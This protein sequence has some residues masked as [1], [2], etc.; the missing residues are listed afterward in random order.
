MPGRMQGVGS[1]VVLIRQ[2]RDCGVES[3]I[4][5]VCLS[6]RSAFDDSGIGERDT[7]KECHVKPPAFAI[8]NG[9]MS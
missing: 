6:R 4:F 2:E 8:A 7:I 5:G 3:S 9:I 1:E